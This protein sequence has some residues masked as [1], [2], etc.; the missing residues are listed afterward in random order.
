MWTS[1]VF[2]S[3]T[4]LVR[5]IFSHVSV[6]LF[7]SL[8]ACPFD[9]KWPTDHNKWVSMVQL[10]N[11]LATHFD[12]YCQ[13]Q[14]K[15]SLLFWAKN[16]SICSA[17]TVKR[18]WCVLYYIRGAHKRP[19]WLYWNEGKEEIMGHWFFCLDSSLRM[20]YMSQIRGLKDK[21]KMLNSIRANH[22]YSASKCAI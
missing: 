11:V 13:C 14:F 8:F 7:V 22:H 10:A 16:I 9:S 20:P 5:I 17:P 18:L 15:P 1:V 19:W 12:D 3:P 21:W 4:F 6:C 2:I